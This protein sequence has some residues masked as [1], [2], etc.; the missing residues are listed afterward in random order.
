M[1]DLWDDLQIDKDDEDNAGWSLAQLEKELANLD[2]QQEQ[3]QMAA[4]A[5]PTAPAN[6]PSM[7]PPGVSPFGASIGGLS[8]ASAVVSHQRDSLYTGAPIVATAPTMPVAL[9]G[10]GNMTDAWAKSLERFSA[11]SLEAEFLKADSVRKQT[12]PAVAP[13]GFLADA[14]DYNVDEKVTI[15][16]PPGMP[17]SSSAE[18]STTTT[19]PVVAAVAAV[20]QS[21]QQAPTVPERS[22]VPPTPQNSAS[23]QL[24]SILLQ[25]QQ[26][27]KTP[28]NSMAELPPTDLPG[29]QPPKTPSNSLAALPED[30]L[31]KPKEQLPPSGLPSMPARVPMTPQNSVATSGGQ[32]H[33]PGQRP[34][35]PHMMPQGVM[36]MPPP[37]MMMKPPQPMAWQQPPP[38]MVHPHG[39]PHPHMHM[40]QQQQRSPPPPQQ[41]QA[42]PQQQQP[43]LVSLPSPASPPKPTGPQ[44]RVYCDVHPA[45]VPIQVSSITSSCMT[46]RDLAFV[47]HSILKPI[48][49]SGTAPSD[50]HMRYFAQGRA[51]NNNNNNNNNDGPLS[52]IKGDWQQEA[53]SR[54]MKAKEWMKD[55]NSLGYISKTN[56]TRPRALIATPTLVSEED[57]EQKQRASLWKARLL[58]DQSY[59]ACDALV[60]VWRAAPPGTVPPEVQHHLRKL[61]KCLGMTARDGSYTMDPAKQDSIRSILRMSKGRIMVARLVENALLPP[62][63]M[64]VLLPAAIGT[65]LQVGKPNDPTDNRLF[66]GLARVISTLPGLENATLIETVQAA[67]QK[68]ALASQV[69]MEC[70]HALLRRGNA[71]AGSTPEF[72]EEWAKTQAEY[73]KL[74]ETT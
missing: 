9:P 33:H 11:T 46:T 3:P 19:T 51:A 74:L 17:Q 49:L 72:A 39:P 28:N 4:G 30:N 12:T 7:L 70:V 69:R 24:E 48:L 2:D 71:V 5:P 26:P 20:P 50:Y 66:A 35:P 53:T 40:Q 13:P 55:T 29:Q 36:V 61:F 23:L 37:M 63:A 64:Q 1:K 18:T 38:H 34:L 73:M 31:P 56:V 67:Q 6:G 54:E 16:A 62:K 10:S 14:E 27:T 68:E 57:V 44:V 43:P 59:Q 65:A 45:A 8:A 32:P 47:V 41:Q 15:R 22:V 42:P 60:E 21:G 52:P 25:A 58:I